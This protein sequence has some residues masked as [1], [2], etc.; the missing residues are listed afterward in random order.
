MKR[1]IATL[2]LLLA[3][4]DPGDT[5]VHFDVDWGS[6]CRDA[7]QDKAAVRPD[8]GSDAACEVRR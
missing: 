6:R 4:E 1:Y 7:A 2:A 3:C 8:A 5:D